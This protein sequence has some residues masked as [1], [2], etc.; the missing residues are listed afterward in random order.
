MAYFLNREEKVR[1][2]GGIRCSYVGA[3]S[4]EPT[5]PLSRF[6][7]EGYGGR[8]PR[9]PSKQGGFDAGVAQQWNDNVQ[10]ALS[11][12]QQ[13]ND[14]NFVRIQP[15]SHG[16]RVSQAAGGQSSLSLA[17][18]D[19]AGAAEPP[20]RGRGAPAAQLPA[21]GAAF[22]GQGGGHFAHQ[23]YD[24]PA[25]RAPSPG[26]A[27]GGRASSRQSRNADGGM[28]GCLG[29]AAYGEASYGRPQDYQHGGGPRQRSVS[30][31]VVAGGRASS[32]PRQSDGG[33]AG[34]LAGAAY[35]DAAY[36]GA[37][38]ARPQDHQF[39][40]G[41]PGGY[42]NFP[43]PPPL[44]P[45]VG[46]NMGAGRQIEATSLA[47]GNRRDNGSSNAYACG[48]NQNCGNGITDRRT[49]R[50]LAPPGGRSQISFG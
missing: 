33:M 15:K 3:E 44:P 43:A 25:P 27:A 11:A 40:G 39:A 42:G 10:S 47:F 41:Q 46:M 45:A 35:G 19:A 6:V 34:C 49:S 2:Q 31:A 14:P 20:R 32:R 24:A 30:P 9:A 26:F 29:G 22:P 16:F 48:E 7:N 13:Q 50:V 36:G 17:W 4:E 18:D 8:P 21:G 12:H 1:P 23:A 38:Y 37:A 5:S 28:S